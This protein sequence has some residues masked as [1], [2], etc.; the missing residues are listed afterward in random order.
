[1]EGIKTQQSTEDFLHIILMFQEANPC[2]WD[3]P[4]KP[5]TSIKIIFP[6]REWGAIE[7][8]IFVASCLAMFPEEVSSV[9]PNF[10]RQIFIHNME[11]TMIII[12]K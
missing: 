7:P 5:M 12:R 2:L 6:I 11:S 3:N 4:G 10:E 8:C 9:D 1:M